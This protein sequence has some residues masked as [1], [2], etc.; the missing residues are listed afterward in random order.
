MKRLHR[1]EVHLGD[2]ELAALDEQR[3]LVPRAVWLRD[4]IQRAPLEDVTHDESIRLLA[5]S[6]RMGKVQAQV[7]LERAL[8]AVPPAQTDDW[9]EK[10]VNGR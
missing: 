8:R 9:L 2:Q 7:A 1:L 6:A 10:L 5:E 4:A 3:G